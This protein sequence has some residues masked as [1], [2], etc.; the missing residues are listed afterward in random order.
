MSAV[1]RELEG[2]TGNVTHTLMYIH[3][4]AISAVI[5]LHIPPPAPPLRQPIASEAIAHANR[6]SKLPHLPQKYVSPHRHVLQITPVYPRL[7]LTV[8]SPRGFGPP[9]R[10]DLPPDADEDPVAPAFLEE[11]QG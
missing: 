7:R 1:R 8:S 5:V 4:R 3:D 9:L 2:E 11:F 10:D 6:D